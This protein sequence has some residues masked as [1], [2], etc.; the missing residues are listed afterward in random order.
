MENQYGFERTVNKR[1]VKVIVWGNAQQE[2]SNERKK[3]V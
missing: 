3:N 1:K 2:E